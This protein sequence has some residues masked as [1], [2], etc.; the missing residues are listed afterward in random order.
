MTVVLLC[1]LVLYH[2]TYSK[3][4]DEMRGLCANLPTLHLA[5][6]ASDP[7]DPYTLKL[8][9]AF[10]ATLLSQVGHLVA[11]IPLVRCAKYR[12]WG[13]A[14]KEPVYRNLNTVLRYYIMLVPPT[15]FVLFWALIFGLPEVRNQGGIHIAETGLLAV[16]LTWILID[17]A[18][19]AISF[20]IRRKLW[21][22]SPESQYRETTAAPAPPQRRES[23]SDEEDPAPKQLALGPLGAAALNSLQPTF[24]GGPRRVYADNGFRTFVQQYADV[25]KVDMQ[26]WHLPNI[27]NLRATPVPNLVDS[28]EE[29]GAENGSQDSTV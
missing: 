12:H 17:P 21:G 4:R 28:V 14:Y 22:Y 24:T 7:M 26:P 27:A 10:L 15:G 6:R 13:E 16:L 18:I 2:A 8:G 20:L 3:R 5:S 9:L 1:G 19:N 23:S 29:E 25:K 11:C